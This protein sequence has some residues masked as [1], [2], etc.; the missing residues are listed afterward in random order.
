MRFSEHRS[1][2]CEAND[3]INHDQEVASVLS[4]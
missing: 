4:E 1:L 2:A 3:V